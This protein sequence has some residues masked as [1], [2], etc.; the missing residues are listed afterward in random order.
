LN[1]A[2]IEKVQELMGDDSLST[3]NIA[4]QIGFEELS[5]F[6]RFI[7]NMTGESMSE[8]KARLS[9]G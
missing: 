7:K 6:Y 3:A 4:E 2:R 5:S 1:K 8:L 9:Q